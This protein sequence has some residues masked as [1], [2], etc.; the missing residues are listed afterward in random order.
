M[1]ANPVTE[2][3]TA[4]ISHTPD[5]DPAP[6]RPAV[7]HTALQIGLVTLLLYACSRI[8]LPFT[9]I[10]LWSGILA[11]ML[12][13]LHLRLVGH[14]GNRWSAALIG[15]AG[16]FVMLLPL[17]VVVTLIGSSIQSLIAGLQDRSL[18][19][20]PPPHWISELPLIGHKLAETWTFVTTSVPAAIAKYGQTL[21]GPVARLVSFAGGVAAA[22]FLLLVSFAIAAVLIA[23]GKSAAAFA[24]RMLIVVTASPERGARLVS[25]TAATIRGVALGVI[26]VAVIQALLFG[27]GFF[28]I[29]LPAA[30]LLTLVALVLCIVQVPP[31][32]LT[33]P[34][35]A[36]VFATEATTSAIFFLVWMLIAGLSDNLL[37]PLML[38]GVQAPMPVI[39]I[40]VLGGTL[41]DGLLGLFVGP[42]LLA[43]AYVLLMEWVER[44][45]PAPQAD[46]S[47]PH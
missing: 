33:L 26:G 38:G 20:P 12:Y 22:E 24:E 34:V 39:L 19:V 14:L 27:I 16:I 8:V 15:V 35:I 45:A 42:V 1:R 44:H 2:T 28:A 5:A 11:V 7:L 6:W 31:A 25:L 17:I 47:P 37:K 30:G 4:N 29:G 13:P 32:L 41:A 10:L 18:T 3:E 21:K 46:E 9:G 43:I 40:G 36:Y 23:H